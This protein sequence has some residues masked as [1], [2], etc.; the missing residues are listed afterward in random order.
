M[1]NRVTNQVYELGSTFKPLTVAAAIDAGV[2]HRPRRGAIRPRRCT[3]D[4]FTIHDD[5][6]LGGSLNVP[7]TLIHSS[8]IVTAQIA[9]QLGAARMKRDAWPP[10]ASTSGP[11]SSCPRAASRSGPSGD[12]AADD[13]R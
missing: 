1:F 9:D 3:I 12:V 2:D 6:N 7:E 13:G 4:G 5:E 8:N 11:T 10:W